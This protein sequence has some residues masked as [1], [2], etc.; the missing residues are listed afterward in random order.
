MIVVYNQDGN[1]VM[2]GQ[3]IVNFRGEVYVLVDV[4]R[5][6]ELGKSGKVLAHAHPEGPTMEFYAQVFNLTIIEMEA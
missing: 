4:S 2:G 1:V 6:P 3:E 5:L